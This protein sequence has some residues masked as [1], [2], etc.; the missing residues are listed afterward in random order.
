MLSLFERIL[1]D[2]L[3]TALGA[4]AVRFRWPMFALWLVLLTLAAIGAATVAD[5]LTSN[6]SS[7]NVTEASRA[8]TMIQTEFQ[9][10]NTNDALIIFYSP[11]LTVDDPAYATSAQRV[12][13]AVSA[14]Q[15]VSR[16]ASYF[17]DQ[18]AQFVSPD[19][20][21]SYADVMLSQNDDQ[22]KSALQNI[23]SIVHAPGA[24]LQMEITGGIAA[25]QDVNSTV[26]SDV[27]HAEL[28]TIPITLFLLL[29]VFRTFV[30]A[31]LPVTLGAAIVTS[32]LALLHVVALWTKVS[33]YSLN[34]ASMIGLGLGIDFSL[35]ML[36]RFREELAKGRETRAAVI[37]MMRT[38]G[39]SIIISGLTLA[40]SMSVL[41]T[42]N[43]VVVRSITL[44]IM[45]CALCAI[46]GALTLVPVVLALLG[47][48]VNAL[49]LVPNFRRRGRHEHLHSSE[50]L[51][52]RWS[53][54][55]MRRP[56]LALIPALIVLLAL[57]A[58]AL[59]LQTRQSD[60]ESL[61]ASSESRQGFEALLRGFG[62]NELSPINVVIHTNAP[63]G[64]WN[65]TVQQALNTLATQ[66]ASD[67]RV[68]HVLWL[69]QFPDLPSPIT[70][71]M[72]GASPQLRAAV[73]SFINVN[74]DSSTAILS[75]VPSQAPY[76]D[77]A[78]QLVRDLRSRYLPQQSGLQGATAL[79]G[80][81]TADFLDFNS[82]LYSRFPQLVG[83]MMLVIFVILLFFFR[84][85]LL[86]LKAIL[87]N[88]FSIA[89][90][91]GVLVL[92]FQQGWG[93]G[94]LGFQPLGKITELTPLLL[95][96]MLFGLSTDYEIFLLTRV[97]ERYERTRNNE[98][99][100]AFGLERTA[101][102]ITAAAS[103]MI[104]VFL[105]FALADFI[106]IKEMGLGA[107]IAV[108]L[109]ATIIRLVVVPASM[110]LL[111]KWNWWLPGWMNRILPVL[112]E[113][114]VEKEAE[115]ASPAEEALPVTPE[116][117]RVG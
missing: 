47:P 84:S 42:L 92:I 105:A 59:S 60:I 103:I 100:V 88:L 15:Y 58:P 72:L 2:R 108:A 71:A 43:V 55:V 107:V 80:G 13:Q 86:P 104:A 102:I 101:G 36:N 39:R 115:A 31:A 78:E 83:W 98:E 17:T 16:V 22:A 95:F 73:A 56:L 32:T 77:A 90:S 50:S 7:G 38:S 94:V 19:R 10:Q 12:L 14:L 25:D 52:H 48:R 9:R 23:R 91:Y 29:F 3:L 65:P 67:G 64:V 54:I 117:A 106:Q 110:R 111:G 6:E 109:D 35:L 116:A 46:L 41:A 18:S 61:P 4:F 11:T 44:G 21:T 26:A 93:A 24:N 34:V 113:G 97:K 33:I 49:R 87:M 76:S 70:P 66:L 112:R 69:N 27:A 40:A 62:D 74:G 85:L 82:L 20:H 30:A 8:S 89:A 96:A 63:D 28:I 81:D 79:V 53:L 75:L 57:A 5:A 99:S 51:W 68:K 37:K 114:A 1:M 45:L